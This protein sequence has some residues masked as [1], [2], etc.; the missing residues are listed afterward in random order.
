MLREAVVMWM[1]AQEWLLIV[2]CFG[3]GNEG[4]RARAANAAGCVPLSILTSHE[5]R[6]SKDLHPFHYFP[7][8]CWGN[9]SRYT[10]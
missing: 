3:G 4:G 9:S 7:F 1:L 10:S 8:F 6:S 2:G 5:H